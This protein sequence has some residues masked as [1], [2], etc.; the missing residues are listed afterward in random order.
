[1]RRQGECQP[2]APG[3]WLGPSFHGLALGG[4]PGKIQ[5]RR[6]KRDPRRHPGR[7]PGATPAS[8]P[9]HRS[10]FCSWLAKQVAC[11]MRFSV[12]WGHLSRALLNVLLVLTT[13][14]KCVKNRVPFCRCCGTT[15]LQERCCTSK[16]HH[17]THATCFLWG[18][19]AELPQA[20][21]CG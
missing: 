5:A 7:D 1:M 20:L 8:A 2:P 21:F 3:P 6:Q 11:S 12:C 9:R 13:L 19:R 4:L 10:C 15:V 16:I 18:T 14:V 17:F